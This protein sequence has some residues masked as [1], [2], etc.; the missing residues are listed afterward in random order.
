MRGERVLRWPSSVRW[1]FWD[2]ANSGLVVL[3]ANED[4]SDRAG[5]G[6][7]GIVVEGPEKR[8]NFEG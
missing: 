4:E 8:R 5:R 3:E 2:V 6:D 1:L 7:N